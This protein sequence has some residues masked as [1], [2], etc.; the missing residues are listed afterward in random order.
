MKLQA[1]KSAGR[2]V[3]KIRLSKFA[4]WFLYF[5]SMATKIICITISES[6]DDKLQQIFC[7]LFLFIVFPCYDCLWY[8]K[9][10]FY[11]QGYQVILSKKGVNSCGVVANV[12]DCSIVVNKFK[13]LSHYSLLD[14]YFWQRYELLYLSFR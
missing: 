4:T 14:Y 11:Y 6:G 7:L 8:L 12:L 5:G 9:S 3:G 1:I 13:L 10:L 2:I